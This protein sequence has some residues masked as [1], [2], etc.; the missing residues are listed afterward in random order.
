MIVENTLAKNITAAG[1]KAAYDAAC[2]R[3]LANKVILAWIMK[4]CLEEYRDFDVDAIAEKY[5]E[6]D[7]QIAKVAVNPDEEAESSGEQV[8]G[9]KTEDSTIK[10]G[11]VTYDIRFYGI[12]PRS[13]EFISLIIN[14]EAQ[15][16]FYPG[17]PLIKRGIYY[18]SRMIS[19]QYGAEFTDTH[20]QKIKKV[21]SIWICA[22]PPKY[23]ENTINRYVIQEENLIGDAAEKKENYDLLTVIMICLGHSGDDKYTGLLKLLDILLSPEK[24]PE[25]KKKV[26]QEDFHIKMTKK[27]ESE[28]SELCNLSQGVFEK[29]EARGEAR[30]EAKIIKSMYEKGFSLEQIAFA[31][32]KSIEEIK[33]IIEG[34]EPILV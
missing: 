14:I 29:G 4:S 24:E 22:A 15:N 26:L 27:L 23:R 25:E 10:E 16:D 32:D 33:A 19:S 8:K 30:G 9:A 18:C 17:Y 28:V 2:K 21:Y 11:T 6:S 12:A 1:D 13:G 34:K 7:P 5:I 31:A 20:Y 3:L